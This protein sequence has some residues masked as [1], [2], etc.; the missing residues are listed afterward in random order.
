MAQ[1]IKDLNIT[2]YSNI[3]D[4]KDLW[5]RLQSENPELPPFEYYHY[6]YCIQTQ[7][8]R[9]GFLDKQVRYFV[10]NCDNKPCIIAPLVINKRRKTADLLQTTSGSGASDF[11][12]R[13][14][15]NIDVM[16]N[17]ITKLQET[18]PFK[19]KYTALPERSLTLKALKA[20]YPE[21][22]VESHALV[23]IQFGESY[24]DYFASLSKNA[25]QNARTAY[26]RLNTQN[27]TISFRC[28]LD[29]AGFNISFS[30][31]CKVYYNR[32]T[33]KYG[34]GNSLKSFISSRIARHFK[35]DSISL[36]TAP[37]HF[38]AYVS[39]DGKIAAVLLG[40]INENKTSVSVPRLAINP[41]FGFF[42][43]GIL[44]LNETIKFL[45]QNTNIRRLDLTKGTEKYKLQMGGKEYFN[46]SV[47]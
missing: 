31:L 32:R 45:I 43:P 40:F 25:R 44:L 13:A 38:Y 3:K 6:C 7:I 10:C 36:R 19:I 47:S 27:K 35:H 17:F 14:D 4:I 30:E 2:Q 39:I 34:T 5:L 1:E 8:Q 22:Q 9:F 23:D 33:S 46:Y 26:N 28:T 42:S 37:N 11:I 18:L 16:K 24:E 15:C 12:Y 41:E 21:A 29:S 20:L